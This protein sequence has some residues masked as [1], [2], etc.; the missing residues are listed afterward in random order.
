MK[1]VFIPEIVEPQSVMSSPQKKLIQFK[2]LQNSP[3][4][5]SLCKKPSPLQNLAQIQ[6]LNTLRKASDFHDE[7][8]AISDNNPTSSPMSRISALN[9]QRQLK[10]RKSGAHIGDFFNME[11]PE[12]QSLP[13]KESMPVISIQMSPRLE[14]DQTNAIKSP[15]NQII[16]NERHFTLARSKKLSHSL[17]PSN[18]LQSEDSQ[19]QEFKSSNHLEQS[20]PPMTIQ[21]QNT[22]ADRPRALQA[23]SQATSPQKTFGQTFTPKF[24]KKV[25]EKYPH[26]AT[27][28]IKMTKSQIFGENLCNFLQIK[29]PVQASLKQ[30]VVE[31][32]KNDFIIKSGPYKLDL[33]VTTK[34]KISSTKDTDQIK[35]EQQKSPVPAS[36][37]RLESVHIQG[38]DNL[39]SS[40]SINLSGEFEENN[41]EQPLN[42]EL[43]NLKS[44]II[45]NRKGSRLFISVASPTSKNAGAKK[46]DQKIFLASPKNVPLEIANTVAA[47]AKKNNPGSSM[48]TFES[49]KGQV[50]TCNTTNIRFTHKSLKS[51]KNHDLAFEINDDSVLQEMLEMMKNGTTEYEDCSFL[52]FEAGK[53]LKDDTLVIFK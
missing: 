15:Q 41:K 30:S 49:T 29:S 36:R 28:T 43:L 2:S 52:Q 22:G 5:S 13:K 44:S 40:D 48:T 39:K 25:A 6:T 23:Q 20:K 18:F 50:S 42:E 3:S 17:V 34:T 31:S 11:Q 45:K 47:A 19:K 9:S 1:S 14:R 8:N 46:D 26:V 35:N 7:H 4:M 53:G 38:L 51:E 12:I 24:P 37:K 10:S 32:P 33:P 16:V 21:I 27:K